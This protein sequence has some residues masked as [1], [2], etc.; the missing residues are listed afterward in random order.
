MIQFLEMPFEINYV[1]NKKTNE[2]RNISN[3]TKVILH[4]STKTR[5]L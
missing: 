5:Q 2:T 4:E 3:T 1:T